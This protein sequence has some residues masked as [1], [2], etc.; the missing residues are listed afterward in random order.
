[1]QR[2]L[3]QPSLLQEHSPTSSQFRGMFARAAGRTAV[4]AS[5]QTRH[6]EK[7]PGADRIPVFRALAVPRSLVD[8]RDSAVDPMDTSMAAEAVEVNG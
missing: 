6:F 1:M 8:G 3:P 5:A 7:A 4:L 2:S